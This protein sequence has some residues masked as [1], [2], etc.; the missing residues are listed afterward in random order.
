M[1]HRVLQLVATQPALCM[2]HAK[3]YAVLATEEWWGWLAHLKLRFWLVTLTVLCAN[4]AAGLVGVGA[5]LWAVTPDWPADR[6]WVLWAVP[7]TP[8]ALAIWGVV[9]LRA[10]SNSQPMRA[11]REQFALD[12]AAL[13]LAE[14][15]GTPGTV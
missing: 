8:L 12:M 6:A 13:N 14:P 9:V 7:L 4:L 3:G 5:L 15:A 2:A 11:V 10:T 1:N